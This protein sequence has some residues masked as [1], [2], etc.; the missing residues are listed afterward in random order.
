MFSGSS[1]A[2]TP[3]RGG[4]GN[5]GPGLQQS[6]CTE[7]DEIVASDNEMVQ[8]AQAQFRGQTGEGVREFPVLP[9]WIRTTAGMVV[10]Q[11]HAAGMMAQSQFENLPRIKSLWDM[12]FIYQKL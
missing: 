10:H 12:L 1:G 4:I 11:N 6:R 5:R 9:G 8:Q 3:Y 7:A 2:S